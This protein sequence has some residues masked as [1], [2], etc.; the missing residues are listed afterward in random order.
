MC[1]MKKQRVASGKPRP[2]SITAKG[3][4]KADKQEGKKYDKK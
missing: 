1:P 4:G 2:K 3:E